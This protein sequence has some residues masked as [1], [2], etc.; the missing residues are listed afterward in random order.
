MILLQMCCPF[1]QVLPKGKLRQEGA[2]SYLRFIEVP[3]V[4]FVV[5]NF[6][7]LLFLFI[8]L[9]VLSG[10]NGYR[11]VLLGFWIFGQTM[12]ELLDFRLAGTLDSHFDSFVNVLDVICMAVIH[13]AVSRGSVALLFCTAVQPLCA[14][15][16][17]RF[18]RSVSERCCDRNLGQHPA[19]RQHAG[20]SRISTCRQKMIVPGRVSKSVES[21]ARPC[22]AAG[23]RRVVALCRRAVVDHRL[24]AARLQVHRSA[25]AARDRRAGPTGVHA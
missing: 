16:T 10:A 1:H 8:Y 24:A 17:Q 14:R 18:S 2:F 15:F 6:F 11:W 3:K 13:I 5:H 22:T 7:Y 19:R 4:K 23:V 9:S 21:D 20:A 25:A 12:D